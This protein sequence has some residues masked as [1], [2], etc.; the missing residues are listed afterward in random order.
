MPNKG[1]RKAK[2]PN[3]LEA[4]AG[5]GGIVSAIAESMGVAW[6]TAKTA[7][8]ENPK[9]QEL[10]EAEL[11]KRLDLAESVVV[12]NIQMAVKQQ[13]KGFFADT[14]DAK[15]YLSKKGKK[16][17]YGEKLAIEGEVK[18]SWKDFINGSDGDPSADSK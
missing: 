16:R 8:D 1:S 3:L 12:M 5:S 4:I 10:L 13:K 17:E 14:S 6:G 2:L 7:I 18:H 9:A 11:E 15:W